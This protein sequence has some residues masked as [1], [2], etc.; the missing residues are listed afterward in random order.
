MKKR[1]KISDRS[2]P[3]KIP[4]GVGIGLLLYSLIIIFVEYPIRKA[5][6]NLIVQS[7]KPLF[8]KI[9]R[10]LLYNILLKAPLRSRFSID[11][12]YSK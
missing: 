7:S 5:W 11:I 9:H 4:I 12:V 1:N 2:D 10:S 8:F 3:Y 6:I